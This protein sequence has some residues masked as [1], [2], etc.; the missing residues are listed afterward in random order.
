MQLNWWLS[1]LDYVFLWYGMAFVLLAVIAVK[2]SWT[3]HLS[4]LNWKWLA[5]FGFLHGINEWLDMLALS[6]Y[7]SADFTAF[8]LVIL[9]ISFV[10]LLEFGLRY[11]FDFRDRRGLIIRLLLIGA[12]C[13]VVYFEIYGANA[14]SR[15][16]LGFTGAFIT[17]SAL[18]C[19]A[20]RYRPAPRN[21]LQIAAVSM[22]VYAVFIGLFGPKGAHMPLSI[23]NDELWLTLT[24]FPV[25]VA[26]TLAAAVCLFGVWWFGRS[27][28]H[29]P[30]HDIIFRRL[31]F[32]LLLPLLLVGGWFATEWRADFAD[33]SFRR[34]ILRLGA[35]I[36]QTINPDRIRLLNFSLEDRNNEAF[37]RLRKQLTEFGTQK[38][39]LKAIV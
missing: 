5:L 12:C 32:P 14:A 2:I 26:R 7:Q 25:Q 27:L 13:A 6:I 10:M 33:K 4:S 18:W 21:G 22:L 1:Q 28:N 20:K 35:G 24:G 3:D 31:M 38:P 9:V 37:I 39:G 11:F 16:C 34:E 23:A 29:R 19:A 30:A 36:A 15:L 8:R 17:A